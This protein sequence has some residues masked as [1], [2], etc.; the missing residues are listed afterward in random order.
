MGTAAQLKNIFR[1]SKG[2]KQN[3]GNASAVI[4]IPEKVQQTNYLDRQAGGQNKKGK[5]SRQN[6]D[7]RTQQAKSQL[8]KSRLPAAMIYQ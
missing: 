4:E 8:N 7:K 1:V 3:T 2:S 5:W 6:V